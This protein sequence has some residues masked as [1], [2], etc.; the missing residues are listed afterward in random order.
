MCALRG[1]YGVVDVVSRVDVQFTVG[2]WCVFW[3]VWVLFLV[4][5]SWCV[6]VGDG[7]VCVSVRD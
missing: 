6:A 2:L 3:P 5:V 4:G 7:F 1:G